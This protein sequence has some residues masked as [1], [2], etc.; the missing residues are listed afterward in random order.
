MFGKPKDPHIP[1]VCLIDLAE[2]RIQL[3][4][5]QEE[6][7]SRCPSCMTTIAALIRQHEKAKME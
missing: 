7:L 5:E 2:D 6:H 1:I 3:D 4:A